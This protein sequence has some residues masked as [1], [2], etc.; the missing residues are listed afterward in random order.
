MSFTNTQL[1]KLKASIR[2]QFVRER[3]VAGKVLHYLEGWHIISEAN[4]IFGRVPLRGVAG[5]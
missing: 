2:P 1:R 3:E 4:R 5:R